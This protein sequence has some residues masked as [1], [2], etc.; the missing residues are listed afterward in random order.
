VLLCVL[1]LHIALRGSLILTLLHEIICSC[2]QVGAE[3]KEFEKIQRVYA[4]R[5]AIVQLEIYDKDN[6]IVTLDA[7]LSQTLRDVTGQAY[8]LLSRAHEAAS[9]AGSEADG[10][11]APP[12][13]TLPRECASACVIIAAQVAESLSFALCGSVG[14]LPSSPVCASKQPSGGNI[15]RAR[16]VTVAS[17]WHRQLC[18]LVV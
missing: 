7:P 6:R 1:L 17:S 8:E 14:S 11:P 10:E 9:A 2:S 4:I 16:G 18:C 15:R 3:N 12:P 5:Q 13:S